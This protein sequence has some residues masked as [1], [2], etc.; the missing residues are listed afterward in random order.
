MTKEYFLFSFFAFSLCSDYNQ[1]AFILL[2]SF[3][4][5]PCSLSALMQES[6]QFYLLKRI[7]AVDR[8]LSLSLSPSPSASLISADRGS[9]ASDD[10]LCKVEQL[11][12]HLFLAFP[13]MMQVWGNFLIY[14]WH[15]M[16]ILSCCWSCTLFWWNWGF[17]RW[18]I[19]HN[20]V[21]CSHTCCI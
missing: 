18:W 14:L 6:D 7:P 13:N 8:S 16:N 20:G 5:A 12:S 9:V 4:F 2:S 15:F 11:W 19:N 21:F 17:W 3:I 10:R 1:T